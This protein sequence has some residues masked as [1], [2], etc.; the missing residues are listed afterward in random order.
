MD[1]VMEST[2]LHPSQT[3]SVSCLA[4]MTAET[5]SMIPQAS[6]MD[7]SLIP[8]PLACFSGCHLGT[9]PDCTGQEPLWLLVAIFVHS[10]IFITLCTMI[11]GNNARPNMNNIPC[12]IIDS[13]PGFILIYITLFL[14][15][16]ICQLVGLY[17]TIFPSKSISSALSIYLSLSAHECMSRCI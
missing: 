7:G 9:V 10:L 11:H 3:E 17:T 13:V 1:T 6:K 14:I 8:R 16:S 5:N 12:S 4:Q 2:L 15:S